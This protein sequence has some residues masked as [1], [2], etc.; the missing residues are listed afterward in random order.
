MNY[1]VENIF[2]HGKTVLTLNNL[3]VDE[4]R[5]VES[6]GIHAFRFCDRL[7]NILP[8]ILYTSL[9]FLGGFGTNP[10]IP[11][12][13]SKPTFWMEMANEAF[14]KRATG[15]QWQK[16]TDVDVEIDEKEIHSGDFIAITRFDGIDQII[17]YGAGSTAG[18]STMALWID[19]ELHVVE[20][21]DGWYWPKH[22]IQRNKFS[23]WVQWAKNAGFNVVVLPL[24]PEYRAIFNETAV[25]EWFK[26]VEGLPY[27]YHNFLFGWVDTANK[28]FP[29]LLDIELVPVIFSILEKIKPT[30]VD[31]FLNQ[32]LN[33]RLNTT[34]FF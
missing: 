33:K 27:G 23:Q 11:V 20:S 17:Q 8:D 16:R 12:F 10:N 2:F 26:T 6:Y 28:S 15:Y 22:G 31:I 1:H 19:G 32:A 25:I 13:G 7:T 30:V 24:A 3:S 9:L 29:P 34:V 4:M 14:I 5:N 21:Q 18:H